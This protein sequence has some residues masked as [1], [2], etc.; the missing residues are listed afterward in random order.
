MKYIGFG[1]GT[2]WDSRNLVGTTELSPEEGFPYRGKEGNLANLSLKGTG[3]AKVENAYSGATSRK[4]WKESIYGEELM[5]GILDYNAESS[6]SVLTIRSLRD[7]GYQTNLR[8]AD[9]YEIPQSRRLRRMDS[10]IST[11]AVQALAIADDVIEFPHV[12]VVQE[13]QKK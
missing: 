4:H 2:S 7:L 5:T 8:L 12:H 3:A 10:K 6:L 13:R 11:K 1:F 9:Y